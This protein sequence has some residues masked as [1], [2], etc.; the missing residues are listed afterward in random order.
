MKMDETL[1]E[2]GACGLLP[3]EGDTVYIDKYKGIEITH[4]DEKYLVVNDEDIVAY[5]RQ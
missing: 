4:G 5:W 3:Q 2:L 1:Y